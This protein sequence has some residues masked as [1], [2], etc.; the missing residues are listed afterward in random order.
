MPAVGAATAAGTAGLPWWAFAVFALAAVALCV[1]CAGSLRSRRRGKAYG[2][3]PT[4][5]ADEDV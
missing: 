2:R 3:A 1:R 4:G 5:S